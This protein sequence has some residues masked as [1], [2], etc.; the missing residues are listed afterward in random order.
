[1]P[2]P[3]RQDAFGLIHPLG[4]ASKY[5]YLP[6]KPQFQLAETLDRE[7]VTALVVPRRAAVFDIAQESPTNTGPNS[8]GIV[9]DANTAS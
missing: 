9:F 5:L 2:G 7:R 1:M 8:A 6:T 3:R 4:S